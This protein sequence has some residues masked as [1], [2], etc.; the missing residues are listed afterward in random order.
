[1]RLSKKVKYWAFF[2][3]TS[4]YELMSDKEYKN[5]EIDSRYVINLE[6]FE[7]LKAAKDYLLYHF[8]AEIQ[9]AKR[10]IN[11]IKEYKSK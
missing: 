5:R 10:A 8:K 4:S 7:S 2:E 3:S 11:Q 9:D 6:Q 1:M